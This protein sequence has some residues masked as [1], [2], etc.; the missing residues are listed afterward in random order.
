ML[1]FSANL[2][3]SIRAQIF[4]S[5]FFFPR[6]KFSFENTSLYYDVRGLTAFKRRVHQASYKLHIVSRQYVW[7]A[8][9]RLKTCNCWSV[10]VERQH[11]RMSNLKAWKIRV[12][13]IS[14]QS[15]FFLTEKAKVLRTSSQLK[16]LFLEHSQLVV[17]KYSTVLDQMLHTYF[18]APIAVP[19]TLSNLR[20][21][22]SNRCVQL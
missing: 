4:F 3:T 5:S 2:K 9:K 7:L 22:S 19:W 16:S 8:S 13:K 6:E 20:S 14:L 15:I 1:F 10:T 17:V 12:C 18:E 11:F 21:Q